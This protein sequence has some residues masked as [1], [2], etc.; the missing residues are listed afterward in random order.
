MISRKERVAR[1]NADASIW[2]TARGQQ[3]VRKKAILGSSTG[4]NNPNGAMNRR[5]GRK[6]GERSAR[7]KR[8]LHF[9]ADFETFVPKR[10]RLCP[11]IVRLNRM[12]AVRC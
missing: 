1:N 6:I 5:Y 10:S 3:P 4:V 7:I 2:R 9:L 8:G 12:E 11:S